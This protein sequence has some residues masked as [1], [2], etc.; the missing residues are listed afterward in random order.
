VVLWALGCL[1]ASACAA[2]GQA[3]ASGPEPRQAP[4]S[5]AAGERTEAAGERAVASE[6]DLDALFAEINRLRADPRA[7]AAHLRW[8]RGLFEGRLVKVPGRIAI[9]SQEGPAAVDEAI[10]ALEGTRPLPPLRRSQ[11]MDRAAAEHVADLGQT[12]RTGHAGADGSQPWDRL[13]RHGQWMKTAGEVASFGQHEPRRVLIQ[14]LVDDGVPDRGHRKQL[15]SPDFGVAGLACGP[16]ARFG[17][18]CVITLAGEFQEAV[19]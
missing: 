9:L 4:G 11:G 17:H 16:H 8:Y 5:V 10:L 7:W 14:F 15:L 1:L 19:P 2:A 18:G 6:T 13:K 3:G 12:G